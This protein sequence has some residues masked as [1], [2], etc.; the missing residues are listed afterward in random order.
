MHL[1]CD[2]YPC[3]AVRFLV[4]AKLQVFHQT[5]LLRFHSSMDAQEDPC[6]FTFIP[7]KIVVLA[8]KDSTFYPRTPAF[9]DTT[10]LP[11]VLTPSH[12]LPVFLADIAPFLAR[13]SIWTSLILEEE[14]KEKA[15]ALLIS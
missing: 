11:Q 13:C 1:Q 7:L 14:E 10:S 4:A 5:S 2:L 8:S 9:T 15:A 6:V 12:L 3:T